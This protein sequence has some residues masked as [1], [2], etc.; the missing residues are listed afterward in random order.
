MTHIFGR[1][2]G[3][4]GVD[5]TL[6][7]VGRDASPIFIGGCPRSGTTL[8]GR[9]LAGKLVE[10]FATP[11]SEYKFGLLAPHADEMMG[12]RRRKD[13]AHELDASWRLKQWDLDEDPS[14]V[15]GSLEAP[16]PRKVL[17]AI[18]SRFVSC[19]GS[20]NGG[21]RWI[22]HTP[23]NMAHAHALYESW[24]KACFVH[25]VRDGRG[26]FSSVRSLDWGP[27]SPVAAAEWWCARCAP[28]LAMEGLLGDRCVR[29]RYE[30]VVTDPAATLDRLVSFLGG[31]ANLGYEGDG[32]GMFLPQYTRSQ[33]R[34]VLKPPEAS[35]ANAWEGTLGPRDVK[36]FES[37]AGSLLPGLG[38]RLSGAG[39]PEVRGIG[40]RLCAFLVEHWGFLRGRVW[41]S[42]R[43]AKYSRRRSCLPGRKA[44]HGSATGTFSR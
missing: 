32:N 24:P 7:H 18:L 40:E 9:L 25:I 6:Y 36:L 33:H 3:E 2:E 10:A 20:N 27:F 15:V 44:D 34:L 39:V 41:R 8:L 1:E 35:R 37:R 22:D 5:E 4:V 16:T 29:V 14:Y 23:I 26:V 13:V 28:G 43:R 30:D 12:E 11:E 38:Y 17:D 42:L 19:H 31:E 21:A